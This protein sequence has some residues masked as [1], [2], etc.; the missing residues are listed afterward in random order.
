MI[1]I[2][3]FFLFDF[4]LCCVMVVLMGDG[5]QVL[6]VGGVVCNVLMGV[7]VLDIDIVILVWF[8]CVIYLVGVVGLCVVFIGIVYGMIIVVVDGKG[9]EV[10]IF[11]R[12]VEID[13]WCVVV[14]FFDDII[15]DVQ[16]C[17]FIMNVLYC[18]VDGC[19]LDLVGGLFD[20]VVCCL[21][22]VG[23]VYVCIVEDF[24]CIL[25]FFCFYVW[26][27]VFGQVDFDVLVVC[28]DGVVGLVCILYECIG[29]E[30][31]KLLLVFDLFEVL[32]LMV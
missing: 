3:V 10:M 16:C 25:W 14:V 31:C 15:E 7:V 29:V 5:Y 17:D 27:G 18:D 20:F 6:I 4:G 1:W 24:L 9:Y 30:M 21:C 28:C 32:V 12:D 23:D 2:F 11:C 13:G 26:Y 22:F 19:V 8:D